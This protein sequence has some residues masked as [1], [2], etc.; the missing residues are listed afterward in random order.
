[1]TGA[2]PRHR[3]AARWLLPAAVYL[4]ILG[5]SSVP[6][7]RFDPL[8]L[9]GWVSYVAHAIEYGALGLSLRWAMAGRRHATVLSVAIG[10]ALAGV[11][12]LYQG[13]VAGRDPSVVDL[14]VDA[15]AIVVGAALVGRRTTTS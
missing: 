2:G 14:G 10:L 7:D 1:M 3:L 11:D 15:V 13:T 9:P 5:L 12:E 8:G 4:V 6:G